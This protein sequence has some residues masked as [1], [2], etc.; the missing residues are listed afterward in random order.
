MDDDLQAQAKAFLLGAWCI[1][2]NEP[3]PSAVTLIRKYADTCSLND[4]QL[5]EQLPRC[6]QFAESFAADIEHASGPERDAKRVYE[7]AAALLR[8]I[9]VSLKER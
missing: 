6:V 1:S 2:K 9:E 4:I 7:Q 8:A 3:K 5:Q